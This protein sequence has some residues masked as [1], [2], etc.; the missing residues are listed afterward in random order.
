M[1]TPDTRPLELLASGPALPVEPARS[2][3]ELVPREPDSTRPNQALRRGSVASFLALL[4]ITT[5][6][7][8]SD[9]E[10]EAELAWTNGF[11][12]DAAMRAFLAAD[13]GDDTSDAPRIDALLAALTRLDRPL[14]ERR[15]LLALAERVDVTNAG[16]RAAL[17]DALIAHARLLRDTDDAAADPP[18]WSALRRFAS[19]VGPERAPELLAFMRPTDGA[20]TRQ[21]ALLG[22]HSILELRDMSGGPAADGLRQRLAGLAGK[23]LDLDWLTSGQNGALATAALTAAVLAETTN[24]RALVEQAVGLGRDRLVRRTRTILEE[25]RTARIERGLPV[26]ASLLTAVERLKNALPS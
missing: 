15:Q 20:T 6:L 8:V 2:L 9:S 18:L 19:L 12:P 26:S 24:S 5:P 22:V 25:A 13:A 21:A 3:D 16:Q 14:D 10:I 4:S 23:Y 1:P 17:A 11:D 7:A